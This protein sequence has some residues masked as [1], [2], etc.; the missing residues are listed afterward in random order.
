MTFEVKD[1]VIA[2]Q[3]YAGCEAPSK[4]CPGVSQC[5]T[6]SGCPNVSGCVDSCKPSVCVGDAGVG[7]TVDTT[8]QPGNAGG[9]ETLRKELLRTI[10][11]QDRPAS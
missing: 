9:I 1:L 3:R 2:I 8:P 10:A 7:G 6:A 5:P 11:L 4:E